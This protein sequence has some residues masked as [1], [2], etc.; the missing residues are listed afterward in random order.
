MPPHTANSPRPDSGSAGRRSSK[1]SHGQP[2]SRTVQPPPVVVA[3]VAA[4]ALHDGEAPGRERPELDNA[5]AALVGVMGAGGRSASLSSAGRHE[6]SGSRA[7]S[8][9]PAEPSQPPVTHSGSSQHAIAAS[10]DL[11][12]LSGQST[13]ERSSGEPGARATGGASAP[14]RA[15]RGTESMSPTPSPPPVLVRSLVVD[16][17]LGLLWA[18]CPACSSSSCPWRTH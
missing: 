11:G 8:Q 10:V 9:R 15:G 5:A 1:A 6:C 17:Y 3:A 7:A 2:G 16:A 14:R 18:C 4:Q 13:P 12:D